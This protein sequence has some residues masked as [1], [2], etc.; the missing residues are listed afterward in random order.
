[1][2]EEVINVGLHNWFFMYAIVGMAACNGLGCTSI[3]AKLETMDRVVN[4]GSIKAVPI[5]LDD[6][7][8]FGMYRRG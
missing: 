8:E 6:G 4:T 7:G 3:N 2:V 5:V 1:M